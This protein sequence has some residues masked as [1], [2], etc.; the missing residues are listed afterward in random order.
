MS[1]YK[2]KVELLNQWANAYYVLDNPIASDEEYD[3]LYHQVLEYE[4]NNP[5]N[6][7]PYS[8]T[9]RVG[10][11][12]LDGFQKADHLQRMWSLDDVFNKE[13]LGKWIDRVEKEYQNIQFYCE[14]KFDGA[15]LSLTYQNGELIKAVTRGNGATGEEITSNAKTI[16]SVP[17]QI[18]H[19]DLIEIRGEVVIFK[20]DFDK[21]N[22]AREK[23]GE[24]VFANPRNAASGS[25]RQLDPKITANRKLI[26]LPWGIG[27]NSLPYKTSS[28]AMEFI[29]SLGFK[30]PPLRHVCKNDNEILE[31]YEE[32]IAQR[33]SISMMLDGMVV[34]INQIPIQDELGF[35]VKSPRWA[36]AFKFPASEKTTKILSVDYQVG[37]TGVVTPVANVAPVDI[38]GVTVERATLHNFD[39]VERKGV[40]I[41]DRVTIIRSGDVIP[42]IIQTL[43]ERRTGEEVAIARPHNCPRCG[44]HLLD[45]GALLK[46]QNLACPSRVINTVK[47]FASKGCMD[48]DGLGEKIVIQLYN[49]GLVKDIACLYNL[50]LEQLLSLEG[51]KEKKAQN[52]LDSLEKT[53]KSETWRLLNALGIEHI[54]QV[55]SKKIAE[56]YGNEIFTATREGIQEIDGIGE[57]MAESFMEFLEVNEEKV[58]SLFE[59]INPTPPEK[60]EFD[61]TNAF[62][63]KTVVLTGSMSRPRNDIKDLLE[64]LGAKVTGSI[65]KKTDYVIYGKEAGSKL[66]KAEKLGVQTLDEENFIRMID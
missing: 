29:Y 47:H 23:N 28:E 10:D 62:F 61:R 17:L 58:R 5:N 3:K 2:E 16:S 65:S 46:C 60:R 11:V 50:T 52:I 36:I 12:V 55:A 54:G 51:F 45:E 7:L 15:S 39:E 26:F 38:E 19:K 1:G 40:K 48:I 49:E 42:K 30:Q 32:M 18:G 21:I 64:S 27:Q 41:G 14:P 56:V 24:A 33:D 25:L 53:K 43:A 9:Q 22:E 44:S 57:E 4:Q 63:E 66:E 59:I 13:D 20:E 31:V 8:P 37:R 35:T 34:K 6:I